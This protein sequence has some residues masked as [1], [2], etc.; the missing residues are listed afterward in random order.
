[1]KLQRQLNFLHTCAK[2]KSSTGGCRGDLFLSRLD[3]DV[4]TVRGCSVNHEGISKEIFQDYVN[5]CNM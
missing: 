4:T 1:M 2:L 5:Q 3:V